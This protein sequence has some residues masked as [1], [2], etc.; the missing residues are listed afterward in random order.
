MNPH[1][2]TRTFVTATAAAL[3]AAVAVPVLTEAQAPPATITFQETAPKVT[4]DQVKGRR[5]DR[6]AQGDRLIVSGALFDAAR[7]RLGTI[8]AA[9]TATG[10]PQPVPKAALLCTVTYDTTKG[11]IVAAGRYRLD[12]SAVL[13][14]VGGS[15]EYTG[16]R[17]TVTAGRPEQGFEEADTITFR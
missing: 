1:L 9:C 2:K 13:P 5:G 16:A 17:G 3:A 15:G 10:A 11:Q 8:L 6:L 14:I 4:I 12:G 7:H